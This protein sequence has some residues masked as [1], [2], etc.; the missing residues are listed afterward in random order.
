MFKQANPLRQ[1][2]ASSVGKAVTTADHSSG[3]EKQHRQVSRT[4]NVTM[5]NVHCSGHA[6]ETIQSMI[7]DLPQLDQ[8]LNDN[9]DS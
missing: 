2:F 8:C 4:L 9:S 1:A 7:I 5:H 6:P 3:H